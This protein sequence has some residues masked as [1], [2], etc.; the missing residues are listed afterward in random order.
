MQQQ[1]QQKQK[2]E[3]QVQRC[4]PSHQHL[5]TCGQAAAFPEGSSLYPASRFKDDASMKHME[6]VHSEMGVNFS[7]DRAVCAPVDMVSLCA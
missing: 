3:K 2:H 6:F 7:I 1:R 4:D 5:R